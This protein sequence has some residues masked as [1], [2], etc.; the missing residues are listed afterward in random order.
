MVDQMT[1]FLAPP[2]FSGCTLFSE[3]DQRDTV[4]EMVWHKAGRLPL[5]LRGNT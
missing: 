5:G 1:R 2:T 4:S 3:H